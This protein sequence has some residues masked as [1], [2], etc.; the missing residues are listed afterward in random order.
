MRAFK[1]IPL[2]IA[3]SLSA[4]PAF[5]R[6]APAKP[7]AG[8]PARPA[9]AK[10]KAAPK[11]AGDREA[12]AIEA[13]KKEGID[14]ARAKR[15]VAVVK[16]YREERQAVH[17]EM[18]THRESLR[19]LLANDS[20]DQAAYTKALDGLEAGQKK[21][22]AIQER[23]VNEIQQILKPSEQAKV[24]RLLLRAKHKRAGAA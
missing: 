11:R 20:S 3:L 22:Q 15:V 13:M 8:A 4:A 10:G 7:P 19:T 5:A 16:K 21:L 12:R 18:Q 14:E 6:P 17:E 23:Q 1:A 24:L 9:P 2:A